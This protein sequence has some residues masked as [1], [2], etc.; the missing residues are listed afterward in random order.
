MASKLRAPALLRSPFC[1]STIR[2][3]I[4]PS[5]AGECVFVFM[6]GLYHG[7]FGN[8][9]HVLDFFHRFGSFSFAVSGA[10]SFS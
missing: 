3:Q 5:A 1:G 6:A 10:V 8:G 7:L 4:A 2:A 9:S